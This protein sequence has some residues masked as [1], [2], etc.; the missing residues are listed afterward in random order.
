MQ[1]VTAL[2]PAKCE[3]G[4]R[5]T[6]NVQHGTDPHGHL[7]HRVGVAEVRFPKPPTTLS[8]LHACI[9]CRMKTAVDWRTCFC[10]ATPRLLASSMVH[11]WHACKAQCNESAH[12]MQITAQINS[13]ERERT[14]AAN[15]CS[16][17]RSVTALTDLNV[18]T[19]AEMQSESTLLIGLEGM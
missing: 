18:M 14:R 4:H 11:A 5:Y 3:I 9:S 15:T 2:R 1:F 8:P 16:T 17:E 10:G 13:G 19:R 7:Q 12:V 6:D